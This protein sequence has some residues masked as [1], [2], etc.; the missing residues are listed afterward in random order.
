MQRT[1]FSQPCILITDA[2]GSAIEGILS[3]RKIGKD[4][5]IAY[6][7]RSLSGTEK[8]YDTY[9]KEAIA[10]IFCVT[11]FPPYLYGRKFTLVADHKPLVWFQNSKDPCSRWR[12]KLAEYDF[13]VIYKAGKMNVNADALSRNPI[14]DNKEK[15]KHSQVDDNDTFMTSQKKMFSKKTFTRKKQENSKNEVRPSKRRNLN[16]EIVPDDVDRFSQ[17]SEVQLL[18]VDSKF[19]KYFQGFLSEELFSEIGKNILKYTNLYK[20]VASRLIFLAI[21]SLIIYLGKK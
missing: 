1:D 19:P 18:N 12:L 20:N 10:I 21:F 13:D 8:K 4:K 7:S 3:Q 11:H 15:S 14:V 5:P 16:P 2:S 6:T 9:E 17:I